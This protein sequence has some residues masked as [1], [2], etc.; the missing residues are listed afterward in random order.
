M[1]LFWNLCF[2][3]CLACSLQPSGRLLG[4]DWPLGSLVCDVFMC[5]SHFS[6]GCPGSGVSIISIPVLCLL[7]YLLPLGESRENNATKLL[8][9]QILILPQR[10][11]L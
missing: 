9:L 11:L 7:P 10:Q 1:D 4:K 6:I 2:V 5:F 8:S 3:Y